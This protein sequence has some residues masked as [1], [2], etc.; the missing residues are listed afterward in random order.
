M[1]SLFERMHDIGKDV[2]AGLEMTE[3]LGKIVCEHYGKH[4]PLLLRWPPSR[5]F[6]IWIRVKHTNSIEY[7]VDN[8]KKLNAMA[9]AFVLD[10]R[11][12]I[13]RKADELVLFEVNCF[14]LLFNI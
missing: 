9:D 6:Q 5:D 11:L 8:Y 4:T 2:F 7:L 1:I 3:R 13:S 14:Y 12:P 10:H